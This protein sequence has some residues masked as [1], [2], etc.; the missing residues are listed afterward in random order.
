M[1]DTVRF[2][3]I[4]TLFGNPIVILLS[5]TVVSI[6]FVVPSKVK[7]SVPILTVSFEPLSAAIVKVV[8]RAAQLSTPEPLVCR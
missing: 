7:V 3:E 2:P 8:D 6:S 5:D 1:P 4:V